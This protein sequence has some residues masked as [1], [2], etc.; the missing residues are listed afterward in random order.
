MLL[1][2]HYQ[3]TMKARHNTKGRVHRLDPWKWCVQRRAPE[4]ED[5]LSESKSLLGKPV[6]SQR[7]EPGS[8][9]K[10]S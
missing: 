2:G 10:E 6:L 9:L 3:G 5:L 1:K 8:D 4:R 7:N